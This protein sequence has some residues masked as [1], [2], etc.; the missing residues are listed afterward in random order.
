MHQVE[1][2]Y[3]WRGYYIASEDPSS[4]FYNREYSEFEFN[5]SVYN[6]Y[7]HPQWD[8]IG[9]PTLFIKILFTDY[10]SGYTIIELLG[11]WNDAIEND[12]MIL[13]RDII[14]PIIENGINKFILIGENVLNFHHSDDCYYEEWFDEVEEGWIAMVNFHD[15]VIAE[16]ERVNIDHYFVMGGELEDIEWRT[17]TPFHFFEKVE[18]LVTKRI[19]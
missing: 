8:A 4:P 5:N 13:K 19:G 10:D 7:I 18:S 6:F 14:E 3:N 9:S 16:F 15:Y 1:P 12:I 2:F 11:E 17:Y